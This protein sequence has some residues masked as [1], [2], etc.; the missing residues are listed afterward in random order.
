MVAM[1]KSYIT[2]CG[3]ELTRLARETFGGDGILSE[4]FVIRALLDMEAI[5]T[6]EGTYDVNVLIAGRELLGISAFK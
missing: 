5:H 6:Y 1:A 3:R 4:N 2:S